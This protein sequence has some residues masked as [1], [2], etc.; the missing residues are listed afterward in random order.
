MEIRES[1]GKRLFRADEGQ[2]QVTVEEIQI[3]A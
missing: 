2:A 3:H 1:G